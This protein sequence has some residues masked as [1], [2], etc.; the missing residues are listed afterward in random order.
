MKRIMHIAMVGLLLLTVACGRRGESGGKE[1]IAGEKLQYHREENRVEVVILE[2]KS[3]PAQILSNGKVSARRKASLSFGTGGTICS[4]AGK[5]GTRVRRG[6]VIARLDR[7]D[8]ELAVASAEITLRQARLDY[9]DRLAGQGYA[10]ADSARIPAQTREMAATR[11]GYASALNNLEKVRL[12]LAGTVLRAPF[13]GVIADLQQKVFDQVS[14]GAF[15]T[16]IDDGGM[17]VTFSVME[18]DVHRISPGMVIRVIPFAGSETEYPGR[19][20]AVNP[21]VSR[22]GLVE[23]T[24]SLEGTTSLLDGMNVHVIVERIL[25]SCLVVPK[26]AVVIRD[27]LNV[28]FTYT[29]DGIAHWVYVNILD[30]NAESYVV[31]ANASRGAS[32]SE[33]DEV[34]V[35]G[36]LNLAD[37][38]RVVLEEPSR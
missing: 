9:L 18:S 2:K 17:D 11:S 3:F 4:I 8:L 14:T 37:G 38:S 27:N 16:L 25:S 24:G 21:S 7:P 35:T 30:A 33:G 22:N 6:E 10:P 5:N 31:E 12:E 29:D 28:L 32:L 23:V 19:V 26:S 13:S 1:E 34:I 36:N 20:T 15:C